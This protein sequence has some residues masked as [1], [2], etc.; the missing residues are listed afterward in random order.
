MPTV[1]FGRSMQM[2]GVRLGKVSEA[3]CEFDRCVLASLF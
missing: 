1:D 2:L 3:R